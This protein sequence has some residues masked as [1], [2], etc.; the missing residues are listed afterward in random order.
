VLQRAQEKKRVQIFSEMAFRIAG[1]GPKKQGK[2][3]FS[4]F[5]AEF[6]SSSWETYSFS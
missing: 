2:I 3:H 1:E 5:P 6:I 4:A